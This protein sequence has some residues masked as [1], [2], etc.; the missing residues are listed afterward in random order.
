MLFKTIENFL[1]NM[2]PQQRN[3]SQALNP[4]CTIHTVVEGSKDEG[5]QLTAVARIREITVCVI[6]M[7]C[8]QSCPFLCFRF[9]NVL[10]SGVVVNCK[11][12]R[13]IEVWD[14]HAASDP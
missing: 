8:C 9:S 11:C 14:V 13:N 4:D 7:V 6:F 3:F 10:F 2:L 12:D 1:H 5:V